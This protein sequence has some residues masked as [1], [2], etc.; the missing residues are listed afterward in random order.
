VASRRV[1]VERRWARLLR[2]GEA[3]CFAIPP[4]HAG[5]I[6]KEESRL[7]GLAER[8]QDWVWDLPAHDLR[9]CESQFLANC[10]GDGVGLDEVLAEQSDETLALAVRARFCFLKVFE[11]LFIT[12]YE[13]PL[14]RWFARWERNYHRDYHRELDLAQELVLKFFQHPEKLENYDPNRPFV[15]WLG[16]VARNLWITKVHRARQPHGTEVLPAAPVWIS[17]DEE[18]L[19]R[20]LE[21]GLEGALTRLPPDQR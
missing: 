11:E 7:G 2:S 9:A 5:V 8:F 16:V 3:D 21:S 18:V 6:M 19:A 12:R 13:R 1:P 14:R 15:H 10:A 20:E 4:N 17:P